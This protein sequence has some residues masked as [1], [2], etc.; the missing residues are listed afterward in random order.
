MNSVIFPAISPN[1]S[2]QQRDVGACI[3]GS[4]WAQANLR[5]GNDYRHD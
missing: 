4:E 5:R 2:R 3:C 1:A